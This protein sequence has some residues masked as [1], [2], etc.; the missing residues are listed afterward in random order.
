M[1]NL[2][3]TRGGWLDP[4]ERMQ[5]SLERLF[6]DFTSMNPRMREL[7][8]GFQ[9]S[10]EIIEEDNQ[11]ILKFD[12]PGVPK[13]QIKV[14]LRHNVLTVAADRREEVKSEGKKQVRSEI[15]YGHFERSLTLPDAIDN[16]SVKANVQDGVLMVVVPKSKQAQAK[17]IP[18]H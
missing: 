7:S 2:E 13:D 16:A 9:P 14:E 3:K 17:Q 18:I 10:A 15:F 1:A 4:F 5:S 8:E 12:M 6:D 11:Y